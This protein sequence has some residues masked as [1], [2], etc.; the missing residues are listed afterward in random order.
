MAALHRFRDFVQGSPMLHPLVEGYRHLRR[1]YRDLRPAQ[2]QFTDIYRRNL[3]GEA[4]SVSGSGS[5][6]AETEDIRGYLP[7]LL[8]RLGARS[9]LDIPCGDF[10][11]MK[12]V[13]LG[14]DR[15]IGADIVPEL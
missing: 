12:T 11:W 14:I 3:W 2:A 8:Q 9:L 10:H 1:R 13:D 7:E 4:E 15:Y 5:T 6:M